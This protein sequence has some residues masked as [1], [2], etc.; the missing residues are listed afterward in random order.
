MLSQAPSSWRLRPSSCWRR[1]HEI[2]C[3]GRLTYCV[4][5]GGLAGRPPFREPGT[6]RQHHVPNENP[7]GAT[8]RPSQQR[9]VRKAWT[10]RHETLIVAATHRV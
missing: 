3:D 6:A 2:A 7:Q 5:G 9:A 10:E 1:T 8:V 4:G